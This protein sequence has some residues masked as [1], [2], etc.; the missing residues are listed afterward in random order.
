MIDKLIFLLM[1]IAL[2]AY[3]VKGTMGFGEGLIVTSIFGL[4]LEMKLVLVIALLL[5]V[6]AGIYQFI[7]IKKSIDKKLVLLFII[8]LIIGVIIGTYILNLINSDIVKIVFAIFL[9]LYS[10]KALLTK[11]SSNSKKDKKGM[12]KFLAVIVGLFS[13]ILDGVIGFGG[14]PLIIYLD[15]YNYKKDDF[16]ATLVSLYLILGLT[17]VVTY[18]YS[19]LFTS[20]SL[21]YT[22]YLIPVTILGTYLGMKIYPH[23]NQKLFK[24]IVMVFLLLV[25]VILLIK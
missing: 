4:F 19:G 10:T 8:P 24:K 23:V 7:I 5:S 2:I 22:A 25:G 20:T 12:N 11:D 17:R 16:R 9:I 1:L 6:V 14:I 21:I 15:F 3:I 13:G 18:G